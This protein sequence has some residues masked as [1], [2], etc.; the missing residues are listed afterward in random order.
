[1]TGLLMNVPHCLNK[2]KFKRHHIPT[3]LKEKKKNQLTSNSTF[4]LSFNYVLFFFLISIISKFAH[5]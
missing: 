1:M 5:K 2:K 4:P 3:T